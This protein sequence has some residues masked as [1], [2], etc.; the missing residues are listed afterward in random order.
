MDEFRMI[1]TSLIGEE[2]G[3]KRKYCYLEFNCPNLK[4]MWCL[5]IYGSVLFVLVVYRL[6]LMN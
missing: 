1:R 6:Y 5:A 2:V 4:I 3:C